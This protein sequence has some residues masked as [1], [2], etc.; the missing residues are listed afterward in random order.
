MEGSLKPAHALKQMQL[1]GAK[2][3]RLAED[4]RR[5]HEAKG[6]LD[7]G[8]KDAGRLEPI[9]DELEQLKQVCCRRV[10]A[11]LNPVLVQRAADRP[12]GTSCFPG[13]LHRFILL[14]EG[15]ESEGAAHV[16]F[17]FATGCA[18]PP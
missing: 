3:T 18:L 12:A 2:L 8:V 17:K 4:W 5:L 6:A 13:K 14:Q 1:F 7:L 16:S 11:N 9:V 10:A 15:K